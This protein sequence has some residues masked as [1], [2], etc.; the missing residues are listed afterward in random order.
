MSVCFFIAVRQIVRNKKKSILL[1]LAM[2]VSLF[3]LIGILGMYSSYKEM[4]LE[5]A[6]ET[7]GEYH[8]YIS[9]I[10][11]DEYAVLQTNSNVKNIGCECYEKSVKV[12]ISDGKSVDSKQKIDLMSMDYDGFLLNNIR[13]KYGR[14]PKS[15]NEILLSAGI[16]MYGGYAFEVAETGSEI[17]LVS[18]WERLKN[19]LS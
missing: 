11:D 13:L 3:L 19:I 15:S 18:D 1:F 2:F 6:R 12:K 17:E 8:F 10:N 5:D 9:D 7:Y 14:V 16:E 4:I